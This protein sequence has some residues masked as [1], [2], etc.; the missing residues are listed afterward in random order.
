MAK[1]VQQ[2]SS[3]SSDP[4]SS[5]CTSGTLGISTYAA[6]ALGDVVYVELPELELEV[7]F[8]DTI[9]A[10][11]STKSASDIMTP[12]TGK[13]IEANNRLE[14]EPGLL[15]KDPE[16]EGWIARIECKHPEELDE[17]MDAEQYKQHTEEEGAH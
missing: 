9:G 10:V 17:L 14:N 4:C 12:V 8:D 3:K 11:E 16:G 2:P 15:N 6:N 5:N 13:V 1:P 7:G